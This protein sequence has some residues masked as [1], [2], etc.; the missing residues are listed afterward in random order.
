MAT[1]KQLKRDVT[2]FD[3]YFAPGLGKGAVT[4]SN[5]LR[6][7]K[8]N[9]RQLQVFCASKR[10]I[11]VSR[12]YYLAKDEPLNRSII[13]ADIHFDFLAVSLKKQATGEITTK[14]LSLANNQDLGEIGGLVVSRVV[15]LDDL[16]RGADQKK[17]ALVNSRQQVIAVVA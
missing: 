14:L 10:R 3:H 1:S 4:V 13:G 9:D 17:L 15:E 8:Y 2:H 11:I 7:L 12:D 6:I 16:E 5:R